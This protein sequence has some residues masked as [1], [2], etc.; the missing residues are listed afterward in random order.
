[1][2]DRDSKTALNAIHFFLQKSRLSDFLT[3]RSP[4]RVHDTD[5]K[6]YANGEDAYEL[7]KYFKDKRPPAGGKDKKVAA[8]AAAK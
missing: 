4:C 1:M 7:R 8:V 6:Y 2:H 3:G 5:I